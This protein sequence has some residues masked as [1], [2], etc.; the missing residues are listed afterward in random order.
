MNSIRR[1]A[2][3][4]QLLTKVLK[5]GAAKDSTTSTDANVTLL[6]NSESMQAASSSEA[7]LHDELL[8]M[9]LNKSAEISIELKKVAF[10]L[11]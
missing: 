11:G 1:L 5:A 6:S 7:K 2:T 9:L 10:G 4:Y 8:E 3:Q